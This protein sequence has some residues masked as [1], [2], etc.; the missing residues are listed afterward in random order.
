MKKHTIIGMAGHIDH[1]KTSLIKAL[2]GIETDRLKEE[3]KRGIT[4]DIGFAYWQDNITIIDVPGHEKFVRNMVA[5]VSTVDLF[6]LVIAADDGVMP[7]TR[8]H[9]DILKFFGV[10][11]GVVALNKADLA[12]NEWLMLVQEDI[13]KL[14]TENGFENIP[15]IPVSA[16]TGQ[17]VKQLEEKIKTVIE[18]IHKP[19]SDRPFRLNIDRSFLAKGFGVIVTGTVLSSRVEVGD[20]L[21]TLPAFKECKVRGVQVHQKNT[22]SATT[23]QRTA[24]NLGGIDKIDVERGVVLAQ[25]GSLD[26][27]RELLSKIY[28]TEKLPY[29]IKRHQTVRV[30]LGTAEHLA[31]IT[32]FEEDPAL[33]SNHVYHIRVRFETDAVAAPQDPILIRSFSPVTTIAGGRV[34]EINPPRINN[35]K[36]D[37]LQY[38]Q[39]L[40]S[41][42]LEIAIRLIFK[43]TGYRSFTVRE[44]CKKLFQNEEQVTK[45]LNK[46]VKQK[47]LMTFEYKD[48]R[49]FID[50]KKLDEALQAVH[51]KIQTILEQDKV[52]RGLNFREL[53]N[54]VKSYGLSESFLYSVLGYGVN[55]GALFKDNEYYAHKDMAASGK[56]E[57]LQQEIERIYLQSRFAPPDLD[58]LAG[59]LKETGK[60]I[61][62]VTLDLAKR[63]KLRS[64]G[65]KFYLHSQVLEELFRFLRSYFAEK[66]VIDIA[67]IK[68]FV[69]STRKFVIPLLEFLDNKGYTIRQGDKR[70][71]GSNL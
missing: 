53:S 40:A 68:N 9:L 31:K 11:Y 37:W 70:I 64:I 56:M 15:I 57:K 32:W 48:A 69:N 29:R 47:V 41:D 51:D 50:N 39:T 66:E 24:I 34:L 21:Q 22:P 52:K 19:Q 55:H 17:G 4:I 30:H 61:K 25:P 43:S 23:G 67:T 46:L 33:Q 63:N 49:H 6:L 13:G 27:C 36:T 60:N 28:T 54:A 42:D 71:K 14:L 12:D 1:G 62:T 26:T 38:F 18:K 7:Q 44:I 2:T 45:I 3:Q 8:E 65:G 58:T 5:G 20:V 35:K 10:E 59:Q 16:L